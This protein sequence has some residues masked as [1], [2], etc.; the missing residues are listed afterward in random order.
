VRPEEQEA[1]NLWA[2]YW[3][4]EDLLGR[5]E[6]VWEE[7]TPAADFGR[8]IRGEVGV[9]QGLKDAR[10]HMKQAGLVDY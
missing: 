3:A 6:S 7:R 4:L 1:I 8:I 5:D 9:L 2:P 10:D